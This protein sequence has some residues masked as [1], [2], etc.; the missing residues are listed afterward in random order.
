MLPFPGAV[1]ELTLRGLLQHHILLCTSQILTKLPPSFPQ[2]RF[3]ENPHGSPCEKLSKQ[4]Y[5][6]HWLSMCNGN[7]SATI[8]PL[9]DCEAASSSYK[10]LSLDYISDSVTDT[11][12]TPLS[13]SIQTWLRCQKIPE[14]KST[15]IVY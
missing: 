8:V 11:Y 14:G 9:H 2:F 4:S 15:Y 6:C 3:R 1:R 5:F 13:L 10:K 12:C 7:H